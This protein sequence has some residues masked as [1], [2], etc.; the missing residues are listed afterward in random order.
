LNGTRGFNVAGGNTLTISSPV[1]DG[2]LVK[3]ANGVNGLGT[4]VLSGANDYAG[5]TTINAGTMSVSGDGNLG[6]APASPAANVTLDGGALSASATFALNANRGVN[7]GASGGTLDAAPSVTLTLPSAASGTG[8][9][10]K[11]GPG[12]VVLSATN[13]YSNQT[14]VNA[15]TLRTG[16]DGVLATAT[17]VNVNGGATLDLAGNSTSVSFLNFNYD[18]SAAGHAAT[19]G[20]SVTTGAGTLTLTQDLFHYPGGDASVSG[21]VN[22]NGANRTFTVAG[23][24]TLTLSAAVSNGG[25]VKGSDFG[26]DGSGTLVLSGANTYAGGTTVNLGTLKVGAAG[27]L[28]LAGGV[29]VATGAT[30][31]VTP[32]STLT[33]NAGT[34]GGTGTVL[35]SVTIASG[36]ALR[37]GGATTAG[38]LTVGSVTLQS[39]GTLD[40]AAG[41]TAASSLTVTNA[42][43]VSGTP[44][45]SLFN[46]GSLVYGHAYTYTVATAGSVSGTPSF[47]FVAGN[48]FGFAGTPTAQFSGNALRLSFT[49]V[50]EAANGLGACAAGAG[51][52][53]WVRWWRRKW[54]AR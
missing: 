29:T 52:F 13:F 30:L 19:G 26:I 24:N 33:V 31:D 11:T 44:T 34:L 2:G 17:A 43:S 3:G 46:D 27:A 1:Y 18:P 41:N 9:L 39:G 53:G 14:T 12:T 23:G 5:G 15:G 22:L 36:G 32:L 21:N 50:P 37:P 16:A 48:F 4:L 49:P 47:N 25:L 35:G 8:N 51:A 10:F 54:A 28:P 45:I 20:G 40:V 42:L 6:A 7:L 38:T